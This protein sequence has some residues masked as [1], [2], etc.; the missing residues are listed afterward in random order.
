MKKKT[1]GRKAGQQTATPGNP[2]AGQPMSIAAALDFARRHHQAGDLQTAENIYRQIL[3]L[4]PDNPEALHLLGVSAYQQQHY[5]TARTLIRQALVRKPDFSDAHSNLGNVLRELGRL[6]EAEKSF[7]RAIDGNPRFTMAHYNLGNV[8][9]SQE[10][11]K[12]ADECFE[13]AIISNPRL[14]E[15]HINRGIA[16]KELGRLKEAEKSYRKA[17]TLKPDLAL[18]HFNLG[19]VLLEMGCPDPAAACYQR[20]LELA[21]GYTEARLNLGAVFRDL[22]RFEESAACYQQALADIPKNAEVLVNYGAVLRD[23]GKA[24]EA[25]TC[26]RQALELAPDAALTHFNL[27]NALRDQGRLTEAVVNFQRALELSPDSPAMYNNLGNTLRDLGKRDEALEVFRTAL[28][29]DP[30]NVEAMVNLG[31]GLKEAGRLE[32]AISTYERA[33]LQRPE[34]PEAHYNLGTAFQDQCRMTE[35]VACFRRTL[36]LK[37]DHTVA[38]SNLLMNLQYDIDLS[39]EELLRESCD[40]ERRQLAGIAPLPPPE[41]PR[42]PE[43]KLRIGYVSGDLR[44]HP[45]GY[46]LDGVLACHDR[47]HFEIFCYANQ[48]FGDDLSD[49]L[50]QNSD[51]WQEIFGWSDTAVTE[52]IRKDAIDILIDLSGHTARNRLQVFGRKPAPVQATWAGYVGT[53]GLSAMDYLIS[54]VRETPEGTDH[55]YREA[56]LRLPDCYVCYAPPEYAPPVGPLPAR[57]NGFITFGCFNNLAKINRL[58]MDLWIRLLQGIP[59]ARLVLA[60]KALGDSTVSARYRQIFAD[61]GVAERVDLSGMVPHQKLLARYGEIDLALDPFP[62]SGGLTTLEGLWMGVPALTLGGDRF[63]SRHTLSHLTAA[64]LPEFIVADQSAYLAKAVSLAHDLSHLESIRLGLR[65][66]M[67]SS[68]LCDAVRFTRNLEEAYRTMWRR[69]C[70]GQEG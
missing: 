27:G 46:F 55:W 70:E 2:G 26:Y 24:A 62:Y 60:T 69:W 64:G 68:P 61:G 13:R 3:Q 6:D 47:K 42:N 5:E 8:L 19:N 15:A 39:P 48:S 4:D 67:M 63:A 18:V 36:E 58:V 34:L 59:D 45:V 1:K 33:L 38:H 41:T 56:V 31:N 22:G 40:W 44:R 53:T 14:A 23:Q 49:R 10:R 51:H 52:L 30:E 35:A 57:K 32:E 29:R 43:R 28:Q 54:D 37:P 9:L 50:R 21:P 16:L 17:L 65:E 7:R 11:F 12:E 66:R 25:E 20:A